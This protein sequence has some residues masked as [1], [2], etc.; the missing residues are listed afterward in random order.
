M[1]ALLGEAALSALRCE[2]GTPLDERGARAVRRFRW[3]YLALGLNFLL[4]AISYVVDP[5]TTYATIDR[6]NRLLGGG[7]YPAAEGGHL[8][9]MLA[10][11]NVF[12]LAFLCFLLLADLPRFFA[13]LPGLAFLKGASATYALCLSLAHGIPFFAAV[14]VL[15][16]GS[17]LAMVAFAVPAHRALTG[18]PPPLPAWA[19]L[20]VRPRRVEAA[21]ARVAAAGIVARTPTLFQVLLGVVR[22]WHRLLFRPETIGLSRSRPVRAT[23]RARL[24]RFRPL[25]F[26]FLLW[27]RAVAPL[28]FTGLASSRERVVR[29]LIGAHHDGEQLLYDLEL[30]ALHPGALEDLRERARAVA[31]GDGPRARWLKDLTVFEGYHA[32]LLAAVEQAL[33]EPASLARHAGDADLS[34]RGLL[35]WC[36]RQPLT[37]GE[38]W[39]SWRT[40]ALRFA[41]S[42]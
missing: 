9:H 12:T 37:P 14:F 18:G 32:A 36:A 26:P 2:D 1:N 38:A 30:L 5:G 15:D 31:E 21:L 25:R 40:G 8:W 27:E 20:L 3:V 4:P 7:P 39:A 19:W 10:V 35:G 11:T 28:D 23:W 42:G 29:H 17:T 22:M 33:R 6:V 13:A 41:G 34:L 16:G 24:L